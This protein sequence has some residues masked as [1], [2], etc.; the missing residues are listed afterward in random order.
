MENKFHEMPFKRFETGRIIKRKSFI[1]RHA[2][3]YIF[4]LEFCFAFLDFQQRSLSCHVQDCL[5]IYP[6]STSDM[7]FNSS[8]VRQSLSLG[9]FAKVSRFSSSQ[10]GCFC[11]IPCSTAYFSIELTLVC[12]SSIVLG[13][14]GFGRSGDFMFRYTSLIYVRKFLQKDLST[15]SIMILFYIVQIDFFLIVKVNI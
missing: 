13:D 3:A 14:N 10:N 15:L 9:V 6:V 7:R 8:T 11:N 4:N 1:P 2:D 12:I 5:C